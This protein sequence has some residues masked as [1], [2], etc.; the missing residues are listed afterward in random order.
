MVKTHGGAVASNINHEEQLRRSVMCCMLW[1]NNFYETGEEIADRIKNL[2]GKVAPEKVAAIA[3]QARTVQKLRHVPLLLAREMSRLPEHKTLISNLL[4]EIIQRPDELA[5]FLAIYWKDGKC[6][7]AAQ[8]KK[9]LAKAFGNFNEYQLAKYNSQKNAI[10][11][12]DVLFLCHAKPDQKGNGRPKKHTRKYKDGNTKVLLR[13][14]DALY[15]KLAKNELTTPDTWEVQL[16]SGADK[17]AT[18]ERLMIEEKL[19]ALAFIRNLRNMEQT[20]VD[21]GMVKEY[22]K[23]VPLDRVLPFRFIAAA[24]ACPVWESIIEDMMLRCVSKVDKL[25]GKTILVVDVS[26]SMDGKKISAK[27]DLERLDAAGA[28]AILVREIAEESVI[29]ATA[30]DDVRRVHA[31]MIVPNR[32]GFA[33]SDIFSKMQL[34][35]EIGYGGIFLKQCMDFIGAKEQGQASRVIV[36]TDEQDCDNKCNPNT[37]DAFGDENYLINICNDKNGIGYGKWTH[38][39]GWSEAVIDFIR[40]SEMPVG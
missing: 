39:S 38:I 40:M 20:R 32:R 13:H 11:L 4:P 33:L 7:I 22:A 25:P 36:I 12:R 31:T 34:A 21:A 10:K 17:K 16:S 14:S 15:T 18:F 3:I 5:E 28:L 37:A 1:E 27:S 35:H 2:V 30:G 9:G 19:G 8:V 6:P 26:G 24:R 29:Y 23:Q